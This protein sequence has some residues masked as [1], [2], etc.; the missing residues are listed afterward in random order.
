MRKVSRIWARKSNRAGL[1][2]DSDEAHQNLSLGN[3][4]SPVAQW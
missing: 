2:G 3:G 4:Q 1:D